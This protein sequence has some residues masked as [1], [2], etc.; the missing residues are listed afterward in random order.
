MNC[1]K[2]KKEIKESADEQVMTAFAELAKDGYT[3]IIGVEIICPHCNET[4][5]YGNFS[6]EFNYTH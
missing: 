3:S 4:A 2:C 1:G 6:G 5:G